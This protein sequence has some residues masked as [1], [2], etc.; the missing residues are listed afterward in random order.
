MVG[1]K[2]KSWLFIIFLSK[3]QTRWKSIRLGKLKKG[4]KQVNPNYV[5]KIC[6]TNVMDISVN[7]LPSSTSKLHTD[8]ISKEDHNVNPFFHNVEKW[9]NIL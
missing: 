5:E 8:L 7:V 2:E 6:K 4:K 3:Q 9:P 1:C